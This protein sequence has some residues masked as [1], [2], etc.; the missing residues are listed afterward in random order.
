MQA[1]HARIVKLQRLVNRLAGAVFGDHCSPIS[2][3]TILSSQACGCDHN[4]HVIKQHP[5]A[6]TMGKVAIVFGT[7]P[8][9][10]GVPPLVLLQY[11]TLMLILFVFGS[12]VEVGE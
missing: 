5:Y 3:T 7:L 11:S 9:G 10:W 2:E 8:I 12:R 6:L 1:Y 4:A